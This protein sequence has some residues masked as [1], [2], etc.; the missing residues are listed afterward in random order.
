MSDEKINYAQFYAIK[1]ECEQRIQKICPGIPYSSGIYFFHRVDENGIRR[2]YCGQAVHLC[3]RA[4]KHLVEHD[5]I[6]LSLKSHGFYSEDNP[7]GWKLSFQTFPEHEID[8]KEKLY[9]RK[10]ADAGFQMYNVSLGGQG[11]NRAK[12]Q[13]AERKPSKKYRDGL[14]LG[15]KALAHELTRIID[16]HLQV[17]LKPEKQNNKTSIQQFE[18]FK[19]LIDEKSYEKES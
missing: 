9:I 12:G 4:A 15:K 6:A 19:T 13:L 5:H 2:G 1:A 3:E 7:Y 17:S 18:K 14:R 10:Y 11:K 8:A 16:T